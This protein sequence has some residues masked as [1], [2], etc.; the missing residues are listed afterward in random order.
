MPMPVGVVLS[1]AVSVAL[2]ASPSPPALPRLILS[3]QK[4]A[5]GKLTVRV[6][7]VG[8]QPLVLVGRTYLALLS[9]RFD[10]AQV[11]V[12]WGEVTTL[13]LPT[14]SRPM[15]LAARQ[16]LDFPLDLRAVLWSP[17]RSGL[18]P[19]HTL[20]RGVRPGDY[21]L[22]VRLVD[23]REAWWQSGGIPITVSQGGGVT[24]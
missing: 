14:T 3:L 6:E 7:N 8:K 22:Q 16:K 21:E 10:G 12:Y 17:D 19:G 23:E 2:A 18:G 24:F 15:R 9:E 13:A 20:A 5:P 4:S 11:P 1:V